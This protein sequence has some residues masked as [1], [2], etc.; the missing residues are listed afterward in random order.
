MSQGVATLHRDW[1]CAAG[2][3]ARARTFD[4]K[5]PHHPCPKVG[6]LMVALVAAG[7]RAKVTTNERGDYVGKELVQTDDEGRVIMSTTV[8]RDD[9]ED[10]TVYAPCATVETEQLSG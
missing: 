10:C 2:C 6:G 1:A 4:A 5:L 9:G 7:T 3:D 8:T